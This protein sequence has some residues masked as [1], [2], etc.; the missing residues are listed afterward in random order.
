MKNLK[1]LSDIELRVYDSIKF[2][3]SES[4]IYSISSFTGERV[5]DVKSTISNLINYGLLSLKSNS[6]RVVC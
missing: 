4:D 3:D 6:N 2:N 5:S 1:E